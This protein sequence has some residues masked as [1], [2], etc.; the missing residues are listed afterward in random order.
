MSSIDRPYNEKRDYIRM[1][2]NSPVHIRQA[3]NDYE[4]VCKDLSGA[5]M[6]IETNQALQVGTELEISIEQKADTHLPFNAIAEV[7][8][9]DDGPDGNY[10]VGLSIKQIHE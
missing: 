9:I 5:G 7:S 3:G 6:L 2:I 4:G 10:I 8:R 1:R